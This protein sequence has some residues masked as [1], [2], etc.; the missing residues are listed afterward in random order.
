MGGFADV[1]GRVFAWME[2]V[3]QSCGGD[4]GL[5]TGHE[6]EH[7]LAQHGTECA[8]RAAR[9]S[10]RGGIGSG[11]AHVLRDR[12]GRCALRE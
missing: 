6:T 3:R 7:C 12:Q 2:R 4:Y 1:L 5:D 9:S 11:P 8:G 10:E